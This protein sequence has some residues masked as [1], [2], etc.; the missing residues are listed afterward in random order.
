MRAEVMARAADL[1][2]AHGAD[3]DEAIRLWSA[4]GGVEGGRNAQAWLSVAFMFARHHRLIGSDGSL[5]LQ[6]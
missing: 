4:T 6:D 1:A 5:Y 2:V 3:V